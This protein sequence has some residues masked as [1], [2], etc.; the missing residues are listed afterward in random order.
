[1]QTFGP[2]LNKDIRRRGYARQYDNCFVCFYLREQ[3]TVEWLLWHSE[4]KLINWRMATKGAKKLTLVVFCYAGCSRL[5]S[6]ASALPWREK[7][8]VPSTLCSDVYDDDN[9]SS[10]TG[11]QV[12]RHVSNIPVASCPAH[13]HK[14]Q[15]IWWQ[16]KKISWFLWR[17]VNKGNDS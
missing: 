2:K 16:W 3:F 14:V 11:V 4:L 8:Y 12:N 13:N 7:Y 9:V 1:M 10:M 6:S 5:H 17:I 15:W